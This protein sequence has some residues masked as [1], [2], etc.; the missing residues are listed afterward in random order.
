MV[1]AIIMLSCKKGHSDWVISFDSNHCGCHNNGDPCLII[2]CRT[3]IKE[4]IEND[5]E[6]PKGTYI[7][8]NQHTIEELNP[9]IR[10]LKVRSKDE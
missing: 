5:T 10:N 1:H 2:N 6:M 9:K 4:S 7:P 8:I 3:C